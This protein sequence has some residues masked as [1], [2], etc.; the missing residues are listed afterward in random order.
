[1]PALKYWDIAQSKYLAVL[2]TGRPGPTGT[3][4]PAG[5]QPPVATNDIGQLIG[6]GGWVGSTPPATARI[7][8]F[9]TTSVQTTSTYAS[10]SVSFAGGFWQYG[11]IPMVMV[12]DTS[13][14]SNHGATI[15]MSSTNLTLLTWLLW[16]GGGGG[17][18]QSVLM[19]YNI[20]CMG[21]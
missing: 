19:R 16:P 15:I 5:P 2:P 8:V 21:A 11:Y 18:D 17:I 10:A 14:S 1:M 3:A 7:K 6:S 9:A 20:M 13:P 4:G 12:G